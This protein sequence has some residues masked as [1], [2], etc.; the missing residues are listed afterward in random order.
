MDDRLIKKLNAQR[1]ILINSFMI[2]PLFSLTNGFDK[3][4]RIYANMKKYSKINVNFQ[5]ST[6]KLLNKIFL[7]K[8]ESDNRHWESSVKLKS[9]Q[10]NT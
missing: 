10:K 7:L 3:V 4:I 8:H 1:S 5:L 2:S 9:Y 6:R